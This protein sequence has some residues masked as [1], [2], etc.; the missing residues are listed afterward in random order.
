MHA[1]PRASHSDECSAHF[2]LEE[3]YEAG[4]V[5]S[6]MLEVGRLRHN[7]VK[8]RTQGMRVPGGARHSMLCYVN[9]G[10]NIN[11]DARSGFRVCRAH[12]AV[13]NEMRGPSSKLIK[14]FTTVTE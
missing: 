5:T 12:F 10:K 8:D 3:A 2:S 13:Q 14:N 11:P 9:H 4:P 1:I 6:S 7:G